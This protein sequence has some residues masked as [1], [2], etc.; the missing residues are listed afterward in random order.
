MAIK[1]SYDLKA[2]TA[3]IE[4]MIT[5]PLPDYDLDDVEAEVPREIDPILASQGFKDLIDETR[6]MLDRELGG[7]GLEIV[8][9]TGAI[10]RDDS[11]HRPGVWLVLRQS[12]AAAD[13]PMPQTEHA[14]IADVADK[15]S[16]YLQL[17]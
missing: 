8:Q 14:K 11:I 6:G 10:C 3:A 9:L 16:A 2:P 5:N 15:I 12:G 7:S 13:K 17:S 1:I 4:L